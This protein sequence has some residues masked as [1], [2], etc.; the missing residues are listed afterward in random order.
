MDTQTLEKGQWQS[1]LDNFSKALGACLTELEVSGLDIGDQI[2]VEG[3]TLNGISYDPKDDIVTI[4]MTSKDDEN[5]EHIIRQPVELVIQQ[6]G[7]HVASL[8]I[9]DN[10]GHKQIVRLKKPLALPAG[11]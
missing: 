3:V 2:E 4:A 8:T 1:Y 7:G 6:E 11:D 5:V 10:E 9:T